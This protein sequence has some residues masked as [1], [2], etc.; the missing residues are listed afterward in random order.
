MKALTKLLLLLWLAGV[1]PGFR[2]GN[3]WAAP[4]TAREVSAAMEQSGYRA[5]QSRW[6]ATGVD[7]LP[8]LD[9]K[10][11]NR[12]LHCIIDTLSSKSLVRSNLVWHLRKH[13]VGDDRSGV[14]T[15]TSADGHVFS[16]VPLECFDHYSPIYVRRIRAAATVGEG[17]LSL[18]GSDYFFNQ[19]VEKSARIDCDIVLGVDFLLNNR[20]VLDFRGKQVF[21]P[22][23]SS[24]ETQSQQLSDRLTAMGFASVN[25]SADTN[26]L[27]CL[28]VS[29]SGRTN[30]LALATLTTE[31]AFA[32]NLLAEI[33]QRLIGK[34]SVMIDI[35][36][37]N[38]P[39]QRW[40][41]HDF[42][43]GAFHHANPSV[44][45]LDLT[46]WNIG[47]TNS[48]G[49]VGL[50]GADI[51]F[52]SRALVDCAGARLFVWQKPVSR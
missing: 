23:V 7:E 42:A 25:T 12:R 13:W 32:Q 43:L 19:T 38:Q 31:T 20:V 36:S 49:P 45:F 47:A 8:S 30:Q 14:I 33:G 4:P 46:D 2:L 28:P 50:L 40:R 29:V 51:L 52:Q 22:S 27:V 41:I 10:V 6:L 35:T 11:G 37:P 5:I 16:Q 17:R 9:T 15:M 26:G 3:L 44:A 34:D 48:S 39:M 21:M 1:S 24:N 18:G